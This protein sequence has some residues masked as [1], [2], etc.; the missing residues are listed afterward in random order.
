MTRTARSTKLNGHISEP[1]VD[2]HPIDAK[3]WSVEENAL[4]KIESQ[5]G[6][7]L[8]RVQVTD[9]QKIGN[10]FI[11]MHWTQQN[12]SLSRVNAVVNP[13]V[14]SISGQPE[15]K[16]TPVKISSYQANWY[17]FILSRTKLKLGNHDYCVSVKG[18][19]FWRYELAGESKVDDYSSWAKQQLGEEGEWLEFND[20]KKQ[21]YRVAIIKNDQLDA[22]VFV[23]PNYELP[24]RTWLSSLF[25]EYPLSDEARSNL[26]AGKPG[27]DQPDVGP[28]VCACFGVGENTIKEAIKCGESKSVE[29]IGKQLK[30]GTNCGSC[31]PEIKKLF[32]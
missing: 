31:I 5:W 29:D 32:K 28:L 19:Q 21:R 27:A 30:A 7:V 11:P 18:E 12:S 14:D 3:K 23:A 15:L 9:S 24:T 20:L 22:V 13:I 8:A 10:T 2:I 17:G 25:T 6:T 16:H 4:A 1:F 26:L